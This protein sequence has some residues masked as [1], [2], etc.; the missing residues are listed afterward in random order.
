MAGPEVWCWLP[1]SGVMAD[2]P[3]RRSGRITGLSGSGVCAALPALFIGRRLVDM[4]A[5]GQR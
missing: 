2:L 3:D 4:G 1:C 5:A